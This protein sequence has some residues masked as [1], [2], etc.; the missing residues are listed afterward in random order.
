MI[1]LGKENQ[2]KW[3]GY[4]EHVVTHLEVMRDTQFIPCAFPWKGSQP[5]PKGLR[6]S[7]S[8]SSCEGLGQFLSWVFPGQQ[9]GEWEVWFRDPSWSPHN[10]SRFPRVSYFSKTFTRSPI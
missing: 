1:T 10:P 8:D 3:P 7:S 6:K 5:L 2:L 4:R 9:K